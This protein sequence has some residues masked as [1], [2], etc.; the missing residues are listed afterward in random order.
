[1]KRR[2]KPGASPERLIKEREKETRKGG[3]RG[4]WRAWDGYFWQLEA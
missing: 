1:M 3:A 4:R 2:E